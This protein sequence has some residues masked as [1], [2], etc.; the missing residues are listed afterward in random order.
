MIRKIMFVALVCLCTTTTLAGTAIKTAN[1]LAL[2]GYDPVAYFTK[3]SAL[4]GDANFS[5]DWAGAKWIFSSAEHRDLFAA[6]PEKYAPQYGGHCAY[7]VGARGNTSSKPA[8]GV[9]WENREGKIYLFPDGRAGNSWRGNSDNL[10][11]W[12]DEA[13]PKLKEALEAR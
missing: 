8:T 3:K 4:K 7:A 1:G 5:H 6:N 10:V 13:W 9:F 2:G 12:G 11:K